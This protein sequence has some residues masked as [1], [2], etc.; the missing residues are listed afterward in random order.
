[1]DE[2]ERVYHRFSDF[3]KTCP[4]FEG[5]KKNIVEIINKEILIIGF[6]IAP[7][8]YEGK[9][10]LTLHFMME[11]EKYIVFVGS[12]PL[13]DQAQEGI[14]EMPYRAIIVKRGKYYTMT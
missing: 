4:Q 1:M 7:S 9:N 6:R 14:D 11:G 3:A 13:M 8:K 10:Y 2:E 12:D 5:E